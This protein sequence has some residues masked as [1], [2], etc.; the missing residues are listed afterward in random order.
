MFTF[1]IWVMD[2]FL[3]GNKM[4]NNAVKCEFIFLI[5]IKEGALSYSQERDFEHR[6]DFS[7]SNFLQRRLFGVL[8]LSGRHISLLDLELKFLKFS[9]D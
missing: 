9:V 3:L 2:S 5:K 8:R 1:Q 6:K 7:A 4:Q